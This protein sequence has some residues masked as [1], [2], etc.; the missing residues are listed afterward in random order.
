MVPLQR[1]LSI[2]TDSKWTIGELTNLLKCHEDTGYIGKTNV[3]LTKAT[4]ARL[5][6]RR[7]YTK[8][9]WVKGH[10]GHAGN[11][12]ADRLAGEGARR[13]IPDEVDMNTEPSLRITGAKLPMI[14]Q[15]LAYKAIRLRKEKQ[16]TTRR[17]TATNL[18][19]IL[20]DTEDAFGVKLTHES[21]WKAI[22][23]PIIGLE[24][25]YF[26]WMLTHDAYKVG[27][28]WLKGSFNADQKR[29]AECAKCGA[30][31][32]MHHILFDCEYTGQDLVWR[33]TEQLWGH[34]KK[35]WTKQSL[36]TVVAA[37]CN[38][39]KTDKGRPMAGANR[40]WTILMSESAKLIWNLRCERVIQ[41]ENEEFSAAEVERRWYATIEYR[42]T[43]DRRSTSRSLGKQALD[44]SLVVST[45][46]PVINGFQ[47]LPPE[48]TGDTGVLVGI[49]R[50]C[51]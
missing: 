46:K 40:L 35:R 21:V 23:S 19:Q 20:S 7:A 24:C 9:K 27:T 11:E 16:G 30:I 6:K 34:T 50:G 29:R 28:Y 2:E 41:N 43:E 10:A 45:W 36:G 4:V 39:H 14:T 47:S 8:F 22:R 48:W 38:P 49:K 13:D 51:G 18:A 31:E 15:A 37:G 5:R 33:L 1:G 12:D 42:L 32:T 3:A 17:P 25:Q 26:L 44:P